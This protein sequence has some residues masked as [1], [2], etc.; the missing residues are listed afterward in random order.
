MAHDNPTTL[1]PVPAELLAAHQ[2]G[3]HAFTRATLWNC[4]AVAALLVVLLLV[5]KVF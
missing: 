3:W 2:R 4:V 1:P 5:F